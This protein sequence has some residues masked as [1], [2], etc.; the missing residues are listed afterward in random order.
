MEERYA[1]NLFEEL[2]GKAY[3]LGEL[4]G[5][6]FARV[7]SQILDQDEGKGEMQDILKVHSVAKQFWAA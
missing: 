3:Q 4:D 5:Q 2:T 6:L 7:I 1:K